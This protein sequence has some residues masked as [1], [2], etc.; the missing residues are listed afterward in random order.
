MPCAD[1]LFFFFLRQQILK[2]EQFFL[3]AVWFNRS[4][5]GLDLLR[6]QKKAQIEKGIL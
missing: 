2:A 6:P 4:D 1:V 3:L 5:R